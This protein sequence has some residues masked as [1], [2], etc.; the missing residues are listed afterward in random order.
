MLRR[1]RPIHLEHRPRAKALTRTAPRLQKQRSRPRDHPRAKAMESPQA[2]LQHGHTAALHP[3][4]AHVPTTSS[5]SSSR[6]LRRPQIHHAGTFRCRQR[7]R[8]CGQSQTCLIERAGTAASIVQN[9]TMSTLSIRSNNRYG[10]GGSGCI[11]SHDLRWLLLS[12]CGHRS[13]PWCVA[14]YSL[15]CSFFWWCACVRA[16][17]SSAIRHLQSL[18]KEVTSK[19]LPSC[20]HSG[21]CASLPPSSHS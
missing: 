2:A 18:C 16:G 15:R 9:T 5:S 19:E 6:L 7:R 10:S 4:Q 1:R 8:L 14:L 12:D 13:L 3:M 17:S 21:S 11:S 20:R